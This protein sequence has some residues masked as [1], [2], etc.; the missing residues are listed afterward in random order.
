MSVKARVL[1]ERT[2]NHSGFCAEYFLQIGGEMLS[3]TQDT[4]K[5]AEA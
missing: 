1:A 3:H 2:L 4:I 5:K